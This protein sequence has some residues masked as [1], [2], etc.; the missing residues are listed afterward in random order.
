MCVKSGFT[1][2]D[3][4]PVGPFG[5]VRSWIEPGCL[6]SGDKR[7]PR[8]DCQAKPREAP[9]PMVDTT[10]FYVESHISPLLTLDILPGTFNADFKALEMIKP[11][12]FLTDTNCKT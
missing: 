11:S 4:K 3:F 12:Y 5:R 6:D 9:M 1:A 2:A 8:E 10:L 7:R